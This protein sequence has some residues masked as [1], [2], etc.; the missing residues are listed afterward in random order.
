MKIIESMLFLTLFAVIFLF[1]G[2]TPSPNN[3]I[4]AVSTISPTDSPIS[5]TYQPDIEISGYQPITPENVQNIEL[6]KEIGTG[7]ARDV[8]LSPDGSL[9]AVRTLENILVYDR[10]TFQIL[11]SSSTYGSTYSFVTFS[12]DSKQIIN[13]NYSFIEFLDIETQNSSKFIPF[14]DEYI[15]ITDISYTPNMDRLIIKGS[16]RSAYCEGNSASLALYSMDGIKLFGQQTCGH[17]TNFFHKSINNEQ[18]LFALNYF[19]GYPYQLFVV[20]NQTGNILASL[21]QKYDYENEEYVKSAVGN[22]L[23]FFT[24][25]Q[26]EEWAIENRKHPFVD[27]EPQCYPENSPY[28]AIDDT[29]SLL[30]YQLNGSLG[31]V[32]LNPKTC[33][34]ASEFLFPAMSYYEGIFSP[35]DRLFFYSNSFNSVLLN[36]ENETIIYQEDLDILSSSGNEYQFNADATKLLVTPIQK[37]SYAENK[38]LE[39]TPIKIIDSTS[40]SLFGKFL[41]AGKENYNIVLTPDP[42]IMMLQYSD[43]F[44]LWNIDTQEYI[45]NLPAGDYVFDATR[46]GIWILKP[47]A[48]HSN[49]NDKSVLSLYDLTNAKLSREMDTIS[50]SGPVTMQILENDSIL[51]IDYR[52]NYKLGCHIKLTIDNDVIFFREYKDILSPIVKNNHAEFTDWVFKKNISL[53]HILFINENGYDLQYSYSD[54]DPLIITRELTFW[55]KN[56]GEYLGELDTNYSPFEVFFSPNHYFLA[57]MSNDGIIRIYG[58]RD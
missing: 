17:E 22:P 34:Y 45:G 46:N 50:H 8:A 10:E 3:S 19:A 31:S 12:P 37:T 28:L 13:P 42:A 2:C 58:V 48:P 36:L 38:E 26:I 35:D 29:N 56:S 5:Q 43:R 55:D 32:K 14:M 6:I 24:L 53:D 40:G 30:A 54:F 49:N 47:V 21:I 7:M 1:G 11:F 44:S 27:Q 9:I 33:K 41:P 51:D 23:Q 4:Q 16:N 20:D 18:T 25:E 52:I 57:T 15:K 39:E